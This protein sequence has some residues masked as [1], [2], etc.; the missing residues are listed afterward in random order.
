MRTRNLYGDAMDVAAGDI[1]ESDGVRR[2]QRSVASQRADE[3]TDEEC[4]T[5]ISGPEVE[6]ALSALYDRYAR[7]VYGVGLKIL[8]D[9]TLAEELVQDVFLKAWRSSPTFESS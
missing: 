6:A 1:L 2:G 3:L 4:M 9:R 7:T 8:G 5:R